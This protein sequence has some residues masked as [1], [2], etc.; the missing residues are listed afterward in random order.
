MIAVSKT[1]DQKWRAHI[2][3]VPVSNPPGVNYKNSERK[4]KNRKQI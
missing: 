1:E 3:S 4:L 2:V